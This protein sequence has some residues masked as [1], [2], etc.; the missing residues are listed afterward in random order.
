MLVLGTGEI[1]SKTDVTG[2]KH[3]IHAE[4][5]AATIFQA[6]HWRTTI[7]ESTDQ[8][9][10]GQKPRTS[11]GIEL[12]PIRECQQRWEAYLR[13]TRPK[14]TLERYFRALNR[15]LRAFPGERDI[16][17]FLRPHINTWVEQRL[18]EGASVATVRTELAAIRAFFQFCV[19][20]DWALLNPTT[21]VSVPNPIR[22]P[23][24][25][26]SNAVPAPSEDSAA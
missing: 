12:H 14:S 26:K 5:N 13:L 17:S 2:S 4:K 19:D 18:A 8:H 21:N 16:N 6:S 9:Q 7:M 25:N 1:W 24:L 20:M 3:R 23:A 10:V 11:S 22:R 15:F